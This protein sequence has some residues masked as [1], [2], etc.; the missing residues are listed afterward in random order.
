LGK[1]KEKFTYD[2]MPELRR[3]FKKKTSL[4]NEERKN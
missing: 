1:D 3:Y 4:L 2:R